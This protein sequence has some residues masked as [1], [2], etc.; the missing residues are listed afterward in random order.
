MYDSVAV[1]I[2]A[3]GAST[4]M[5]GKIKQLLPWNNQ[6]LLAHT[7]Q[8]AIK[9]TDKVTVVLGA[10][11]EII[12]PKIPQYIEI[13]DNPHWKNGM[14]SSIAF[15]VQHLLHTKNVMDGL[16]IMLVD[17]PLL[18]ATYL[19]EM[20]NHFIAGEHKI[21]ATDYGGNLGV[22]AIFHSSVLPELTELDQDFGARHI[23]LKYKSQ[24]KIVFPK[25]REVDIDTIEKYNQLIDNK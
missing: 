20:T 14:G 22:P 6:A 24:A 21:V 3:A 1:L 11:S 7:I 18:D 8:Q 5:E 13:L 16:L 19:N 23:L 17:Q 9:V 10:N 15:G 2:L 12:K 25:G 4:R